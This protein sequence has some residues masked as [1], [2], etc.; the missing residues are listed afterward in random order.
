MD[1][2]REFYRDVLGLPLFLEDA[3]SAVFQS[4]PRSFT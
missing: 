4:A 2:A 3:D 1:A